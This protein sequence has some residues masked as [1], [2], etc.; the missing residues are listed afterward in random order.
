MQVLRAVAAGFGA[1]GLAY[2]LNW[3]VLR[4]VGGKGLWLVI[5]ALEEGLKTGVAILLRTSLPLAHT[6][7]GLVEAGY[8]LRGPR[9]SVQA[10]FLALI[11]HAAFGLTT[12]WLV[13]RG[14]GPGP[15][16]LAA[17]TVHTLFNLAV[18]QHPTRRLHPLR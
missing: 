10:A 6:F 18:T 13:A 9:P 17:A 4:R 5:P 12:G 3:L 1:A 7:F 8:E 11:T 14:G 2:G 15:A 16:V